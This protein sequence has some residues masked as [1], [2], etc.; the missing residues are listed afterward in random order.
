LGGFNIVTR[1][2]AG[3]NDV[4]TTIRPPEDLGVAV[5]VPTVEKPSTEAARRLVPSQVKMPDHVQAVGHSARI[6][7]AFASGDVHAILDTVPWDGIVEPARAVGGLYGVEFSHLWEEKRMLLRKYNVAETIS[8]A[9][10]SRAL[11]YSIAED[12]SS[13]RRNNIGTIRPA[14][15]LVTARL[16]AVGYEV[17]EVFVTKPSSKG[18]RI[19]PRSAR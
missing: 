16:K 12:Y 6:A 11:W 1:N 9:G 2:A 14:I 17:R 7:A 13:K 19:I 10:P 8:G 3:G 4:V 15:A 5:L 18:A